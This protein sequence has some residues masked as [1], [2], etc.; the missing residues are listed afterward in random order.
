MEVIYGHGHSNIQAIHK[1]TIEFTK[2]THV[3]K[4]GDCIIM[5]GANK[6][7]SDLSCGFRQ[8]LTDD[9]ATISIVIEAGD[10][11]E[12]IVARGS[13]RLTFS[14]PKDIVIRK[15]DYVSSRTLAVCADK[16]AKDLS[17]N[18]VEKLKNPTQNVKVTLK[19]SLR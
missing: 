12:K 18:F 19:I 16:A 7:V 6:A 3:S 14:D 8:N 17:R 2:D 10:F 5:V 13:S 1:T 11:S 15:S 4:T 9:N